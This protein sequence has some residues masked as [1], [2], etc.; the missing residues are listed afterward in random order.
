VK[1]EALLQGQGLGHEPRVFGNAFAIC[2]SY[3]V[4]RL[5]LLQIGCNSL[6]SNSYILIIQNLL[7]IRFNMQ[8][9]KFKSHPNFAKLA[10]SGAFNLPLSFNHRIYQI[11]YFGQT[12]CVD[13]PKYQ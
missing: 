10:H 4:S 3:E 9:L 13:P 8:L 6:L 2:P 7:H 11:N 1:E 12:R 5:L